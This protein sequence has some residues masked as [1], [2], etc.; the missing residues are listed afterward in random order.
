M[1]RLWLLPALFCAS[2]AVAAAPAP[3]VPKYYN[4]SYQVFVGAGNLARARQLVEDALYWRPRDPL[5]IKRLALVAGWQGDTEASLA[6]WYRLAQTDDSQE[7]WQ[8]VLALAPGTFNDELVLRAR[9]RLLRS[10]PGNA[11]L[12]ED[13]AHQYELLG[14]VHEGLAFLEKW[15]RRYPS[16]GVLMSLQRLAQ[17]AGEDLRAA[18]YDREYMRRYGPTRELAIRCADLLWLHGQREKAYQ[19][20]RHDAQGLPYSPQIT[21]RLALMATQ[22]KD[23]PQAMSAYQTLTEKGDADPSDGYDYLNLAYYQAPDQVPTILLHIWQGTGD[24][25]FATSYLFALDD[26]GDTR[27]AGRFLHTLSAADLKRLGGDATFLRLYADYLQSQ[28]QSRRALQLMRQALAMDPAKPGIREAWLSLLIDQGDNKRLAADLARWEPAMRGDPRYLDTLAAAYL[29]LGKPEQALIYE[30]Q[31]LDDDPGSWRRQWSYCQALLAAGHGDQ[32]WPLLRRLWR[33][34]PAP[35]QVR[36]ADRPMYDEMRAALAGRFG[37]GDEQLRFERRELAR[38]PASE[39]AQRADWV[40]QWALGQDAPELARLWFLR[41]RHYQPQGLPA[42]SALALAELHGN[43]LAMARVRDDRGG[44]LS[45]D[46]RIEVDDTLGR[47]R[48]AAAELA[49]E[50]YDAPAL[51]D[52]NPSQEELLLPASDSLSLAGERRHLG[53][54]DA[55]LWQ[56]MARS[57]FGERWDWT[58]HLQ[59]DRFTS[60]DSKLLSVSASGERVALDLH[61]R[62]RLWDTDVQVGNRSLFG[63][64]KPDATLTIGG[65]PLARWH[66]QWRGEWHAPSDET[67]GLLLAGQRTGQSLELNWTPAQTWE[68]TASVANYRYNDLAGN[69]LGRGTEFDVQST[70]RPWLSRL[71]PGLR[72]RQTVASYSGQRPLSR[73]IDIRGDVGPAVPQSYNETELSLLIGRPESAVRPHRAQAWGEVGVTRN[74]LYGTG[75]T[76]R[77]GAEG[78]LLGRDAWRLYL[79]KSVNTGGANQDS[80]RVGFEYR[81]YY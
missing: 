39:R 20:L 47:E 21:R 76:G 44:Q 59:H 7:A 58:L 69:A 8:H 5:W 23:W 49:E 79:E 10:H 72:L 18:G 62:S 30:R 17:G 11:K 34:S 9:L 60:N 12:I 43:R 1:K 73:A 63:Y 46:E 15:L 19:G 29:A 51:A 42:G 66:W 16:K 75:F 55:D 78:P 70:W 61:R 41:E 25:D 68:N 24:P 53:P 4:D 74:N 67:A 31:R 22:L 38:T 33:H 45:A 28:G 40:A 64:S 36:P 13:V 50:Q 54:L 65:Q 32:A 56:L 52:A 71:S 6:A 81:F 48:F 14:R 80:Y 2:A 26:R 57:P 77:L 35:D 27:A 3:Y 37:S